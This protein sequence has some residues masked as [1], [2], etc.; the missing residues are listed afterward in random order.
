MSEVRAPLPHPPRRFADAPN[1]D[2]KDLDGHPPSPTNLRSVRFHVEMAAQAWTLDFPTTVRETA[3]AKINLATFQLN[4]AIVTMLSK[5]PLAP[6]GYASVEEPLYRTVEF[7]Y[8]QEI[9]EA[10]GYLMPVRAAIA[11]LLDVA[12]PWLL[13]QPAFVPRFQTLWS[14][15]PMYGRYMGDHHKLCQLGCLLPSWDDPPEDVAP[16]AGGPSDDEGIRE[17]ASE[18]G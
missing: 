17:E 2:W 8:R 5:Y 16:E 9:P 12:L 3:V 18:E 10:K 11:R 13:K 7:L 14:E 15:Q 6:T 1:T 4:N